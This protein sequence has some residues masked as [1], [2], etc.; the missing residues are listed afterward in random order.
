MSD[1]IY[2]GEPF[3]DEMVA[4]NYGFVYIITN[5][6]NGRKYIGKKFFWSKRTLPPLKGKK[7]R[8]RVKKPSDWKRYY[9]SSKVVKADIER[10]GKE[11]FHREIVSLHPDKRETNYHELSLQIFLNV[12][13][14]LDKNGE[15][16]YYN[17]NIDR[18]YYPTKQYG[19]DR[20]RIN[21]MYLEMSDYK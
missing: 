4:D 11:N 5:V 8:R 2:N 19:E 10:Y 6:V 14:A 21:K 15:R 7:R 3:T 17:E 9:G 18:I 16:V 1:W 13:D 20:I 12:L